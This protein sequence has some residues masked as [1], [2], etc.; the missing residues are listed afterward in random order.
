MS[1]VLCLSIN[2]VKLLTDG[3]GLLNWLFITC[4]VFVAFFAVVP[5]IS[6][7]DSRLTQRIKLVDRTYLTIKINL[8]IYKN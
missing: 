8:K 4:G 3:D 1:L 7:G 5:I 6:K 2:I